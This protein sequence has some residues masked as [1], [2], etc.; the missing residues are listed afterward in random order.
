MNDPTQ[1]ALIIR[2][3]QDAYEF[4]EGGSSTTIVAALPNKVEFDKDEGYLM[5][6]EPDLKYPIAG[7]LDPVALKSGDVI[8]K[9]LKTTL[10]LIASPPFLFATIIAVLLPIKKIEKRFLWDFAD[11]CAHETKEFI[12]K[13]DRYTRAVREIR[14]ALEATAESF[15]VDQK[16]KYAIMRIIK[17]V[18]MIL[19]N[20]RPYRYAFQDVLTEMDRTELYSHPT[21]E[22]KRLVNIFS[23]RFKARDFKQIG[24]LAWIMCMLK[25]DVKEFIRKFLLELDLTKLRMDTKDKYMAYLQEGYNYAGLS[26][27]QRLEI[28]KTL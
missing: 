4:A 5:Y 11:L 1:Q 7:L 22:I 17:S 18:G 8:K 2:P 24:R 14:R 27:E 25:P 20:D 16:T 6:F 21:R 15:F 28:H 12:F 13:L 9:Y 19:E 3:R 23:N 10:H 26:K